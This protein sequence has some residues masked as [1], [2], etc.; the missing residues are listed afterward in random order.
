MTDHEGV[1]YRREGRIAYITFNRP[2]KLN[3]FDDDQ[4]RAFRARLVQFDQDEEA[5]VAIL[6]GEGRA[7]SSGADVHQRQLRELD[8][9]KRLGGRRVPARRTIR[10]CTRGT[11]IGSR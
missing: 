11:S 2:E 10:S 7:F 6:H 9:L 5:W 1:L 3:A 8:E 4:V